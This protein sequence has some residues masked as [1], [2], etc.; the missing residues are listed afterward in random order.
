MSLKIKDLP[1]EDYWLPGNPS[2]PGCPAS[3]GLRLLMK[4]LGP[5]TITIIPACCSTI[6]QGTYPKT[7]ANFPIL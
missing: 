7:S 4:A 5:K 2:C 1:I 3:L 6:I